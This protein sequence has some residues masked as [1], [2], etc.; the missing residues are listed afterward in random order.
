MKIVTAHLDKCKAPHMCKL[1]QKSFSSKSS[2]ECHFDI[3][4][5]GKFDCLFCNYRCISDAQLAD[6]TKRNHA[7]QPT[8]SC[9]QCKNVYGMKDNLLSDM[10]MCHSDIFN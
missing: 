1:C 9:N 10:D 7:K 8:F 4:S 5:K 6:H 2:L 3:C